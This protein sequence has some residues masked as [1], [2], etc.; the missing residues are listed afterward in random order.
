VTP[1]KSALSSLNPSPAAAYSIGRV[2][3][4]LF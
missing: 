1:Y 4:S 3:D 2:K